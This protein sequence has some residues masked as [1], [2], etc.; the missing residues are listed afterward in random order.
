MGSEIRGI[1][2]ITPRIVEK[3]EESIASMHPNNPF[4]WPDDACLGEPW[5]YE[6]HA[7]WVSAWNASGRKEDAITF[8][9]AWM[10]EQG[11]VSS[12]AAR[13]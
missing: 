4:S 7:S 2:K 11:G 10:V 8:L 5:G 3:V 1:M 6:F 13:Q 12:S 9:R